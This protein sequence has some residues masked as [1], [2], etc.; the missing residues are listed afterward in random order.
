MRMKW[1]GLM[2]LGLTAVAAAQAPSTAEVKRIGE[3]AAVLREIHAVPDKDIPQSLWENARC[4]I[5]IPGLKRGA[6]I[7]GGEY[8]KGLMSCRN[9]NEWGAP[10]FME[11][12]KGSWGFQVGAEEV[13]LVMLVMNDH[14]IDHLLQNKVTLGT[15][16]SVAAGPVGRDA[17]AATDAQ[18]HAE[19]LSWS[20]SRG[21]FAGINIAGG[22]MKP[23]PDDNRDLYGHAIQPRE[24]LLNRKVAVADAA[25]PFIAALRAHDA[26]APT[27]QP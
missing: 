14:G 7:V 1:A 24:V 18:M 20:R 8:G 23:D 16:A 13:D 11:I 21:V 6:F 9:G 26:A 15:E 25:R 10:V 4:A 17:Q 27:Q 22:V 19:I 12:E 3:A 2:V 5:V